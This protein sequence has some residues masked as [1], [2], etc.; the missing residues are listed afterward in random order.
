M[1]PDVTLRPSEADD[2][3]AL[4]AIAEATELF[5]GA[6]LPDMIAGYLDGSR[7]DI[8]ITA[9]SSH[10]PLAFAFCEPERMTN[11]T[12]NLLAIAVLPERQGDGIGAAL[13]RH[14]ESTLRERGQ[15]I[16]LVETLGSPAFARTR[17]FYLANDFTEEAR[18]RDFYEAGGDKVVF[19]KRL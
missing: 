11:G 15:R 1:H 14:L 3:D 4:A 18:I 8:W 19:W 7:P 6:L 16:L 13:V 12:W 17:A 2:R 10:G 9:A 5:P